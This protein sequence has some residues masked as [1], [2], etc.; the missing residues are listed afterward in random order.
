[1]A[2]VQLRFHLLPANAFTA[3]ENRAES[4]ARSLT[5]R[6]EAHTNGQMILLLYI[7]LIALERTVNGTTTWSCR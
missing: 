7:T 2:L 6:S 1:M 4:P 5:G 3:R